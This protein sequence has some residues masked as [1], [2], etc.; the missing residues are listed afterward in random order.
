MQQEMGKRCK[1]AGSWSELALGTTAL[2][3]GAALVASMVRNE[4]LFKQL[5]AKDRVS[6]SGHNLL[7]IRE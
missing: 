5:K 7:V 3:V 6:L 4:R 2:V 1:L